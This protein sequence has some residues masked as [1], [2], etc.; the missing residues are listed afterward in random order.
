MEYGHFQSR[1][2]PSTIQGAPLMLRRQSCCAVSSGL[3][4][5]LLT[6]TLCLVSSPLQAIEICTSPALAIPDNNPAGVTSSKDICS[7]MTALNMKVYLNISHGYVGDLIVTLKHVDTGTTVTLID[8]PGVPA[9]IFGCNGNDINV[10]LDDAA[11]SDVEDA[12]AAGAPTISGSLQPQMPLASF[13][14]E[15]LS[16]TWQLKVSDVSAF[17]TGTLNDWCLIVDGYGTDSFGYTATDSPFFGSAQFN[18]LNI[19]LSGTNVPFMDDSH[20]GPFNL[21]FTFDFYGI[22]YTQFQLTSNGQLVLGNAP[23]VSAFT[24]ACPLPSATPNR[25]E[26]RRVGE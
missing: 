13:Y 3:M 17:V 11:L 4:L 8:R 1:Q 6:V 10:T 20:H 23:I 15:P 26:E 21:G 5:S 14:G 16:G 12:C 24:N 18:W 22:D 25:S 19:S 2:Y 7:D 9:S